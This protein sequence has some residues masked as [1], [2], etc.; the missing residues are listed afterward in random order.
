MWRRRLVTGDAAGRAR[1]ACGGRPEAAAHELCVSRDVWARVPTR[2][3]S[4]V[5]D[6]GVELLREPERGRRAE[7]DVDVQHCARLEW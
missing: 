2:V 4:D 1:A 7:A 3:H 5:A 6:G